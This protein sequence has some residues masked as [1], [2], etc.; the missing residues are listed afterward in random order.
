MKE[1]KQIN[2]QTH[3]VQNCTKK[4]Y[5]L[6]GSFKT[7]AMAL[8]GFLEFFQKGKVGSGLHLRAHNVYTY[9]YFMVL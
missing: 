1:N 3:F 9:Y 8:N 2:K 6:L 5:K 4:N 7:K